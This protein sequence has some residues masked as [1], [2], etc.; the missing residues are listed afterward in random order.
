M[1]NLFKFIQNLVK[2]NVNLATYC[3]SAFMSLNAIMSLSYIL[4]ILKE[5]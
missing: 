3:D 4:D 1:V 2:H 5:L